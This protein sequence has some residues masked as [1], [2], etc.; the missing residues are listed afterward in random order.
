MGTLVP[1]RTRT[2]KDEKRKVLIVCHHLKIYHF[3]RF[4]CE[5][6]LMAYGLYNARLEVFSNVEFATQWYE[7]CFE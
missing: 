2:A 4:W 6:T 7:F 3:Q 5:T 1:S